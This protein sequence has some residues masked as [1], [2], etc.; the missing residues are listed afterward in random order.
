[1]SEDKLRCIEELVLKF[2]SM[3][4][5]EF[6][7]CDVRIMEI[8]RDFNYAYGRP[9]FKFILSNGGCIIIK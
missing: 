2:N 4:S 9:S 1:M 8:Q 6:Y 5:F 7:G 3:E